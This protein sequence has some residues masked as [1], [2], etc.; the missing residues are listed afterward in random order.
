MSL[1]RNAWH[2]GWSGYRFVLALLAYPLLVALL[3]WAGVV[4]GHVAF[5]LGAV[6]GLAGWATAAVV[7]VRRSRRIDAGASTDLTPGVLALP[8]L[9]MIAAAVVPWL[10]A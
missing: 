1:A 5:W 6:A 9:V 8:G 2:A 4:L 7:V 10:V 3:I